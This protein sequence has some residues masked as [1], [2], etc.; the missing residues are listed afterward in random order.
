MKILPAIAAIAALALAGW[1]SPSVAA[2]AKARAKSASAKPASTGTCLRCHDEASTATIL[3]RPH[4]VTADPRT[5]FAR[6]ACQTCHGK[7]EAHVK[8]KKGAPGKRP[9][10]TVVFGPNSP[11]P[12][13]VRN[14]TCL[15]CHESGARMMWRA[16]EH[17]LGGN[18]CTS[19]HKVHTLKDKVL[20][21][22]TQPEVCYTCHAEKR[23]QQYRRS[24]HPIREGKVVCSDCHNPHGSVG[25][26]QLVKATVNE[27]CYQCHADKR[28]PFLWEHQPVSESCV[29]CHDPH[30]SVQPKLLVKRTPWLC[31]ECHAETR[32]P[33]DA[34]GGIGLAT[35]DRILFKGCL[36]CH[37]RI[38]GSNHP[39]GPRFTR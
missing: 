31:Q 23:A 39:S 38:H 5:P 28:G 9:L 6:E 14:R 17:A 29:N 1:A 4:G 37:S 3:Q 26:S 19:C 24:R 35:S 21:K 36:N 7:S 15:G 16:S 25:P 2:E 32:H 33:S 27:T 30:G 18:A 13:A 11:T 10:P 34:R 8:P 12:A 22:I 20:T